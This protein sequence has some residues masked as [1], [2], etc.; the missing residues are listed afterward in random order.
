MSE[1]RGQFRLSEIQVHN[2]GTFDGLHRT[3][4]DRTGHLVTGPSGSG[5]STLI[6]AV[7]AVLISAP[8]F[9]AAAQATRSSGRNLISYARGAWRREHSAEFD[10]LTQSFLRTGA[11]W[12]GILLRYDNAAGDTVSAIRLMHLSRTAS[13]PADITNLFI[14]LPRSADLSEFE[15][16]AR[17]NLDLRRARKVF[18]D[19]LS[20]QRSHATFITVFRRELGIADP[21][22]LDLLY[23]TQSSKSLEDLNQLMREFMLPQPDTFRLADDA[24]EQFT[25]LNTAH[26]SVLTARDQIAALLPVRESHEGLNAAEAEQADNDEELD[27]LTTFEQTQA[28]Q[29]V[30]D[31]MDT[32]SKEVAAAETQVSEAEA[33]KNLLQERKEKLQQQLHGEQGVGLVSARADLAEQTHTLT[34]V[35]GDRDAYERQARILG[36]DTP[37]TPEQFETVTF[38]LQGYVTELE[39]QL[40]EKAG[41]RQQLY[42]ATSEASRRR[43]ALQKELQ[44][45]REFASAMDS[46][47]LE[48][49]EAISRLT[50]IPRA[51]L[52]FIADLLEMQTGEEGWQLAAERALG[53]F[54]RQLLVPDE[55]YEKVS[56]AVDAHNL[57]TRLR[58][59][60]VTPE[61]LRREPDRFVPGTL[62]TKIAVQPGRFHQWLQS[63]LSRRF[64]HRC[65]EELADFR[66]ENRAIT[67]RGQIKHDVHRHEKDD[68]PHID[69]PSRWVLTANLDLKIETLQAQL[70]DARA[71]EEKAAA[72]TRALESSIRALEEQRTAAD[73]LLETTEFRVIDTRSARRALESAQRRVDELADAQPQIKQ[74]QIELERA[75][76]QVD[77]QTDT[78]KHL[79]GVVATVKNDL[80]DS[81]RKAEH[82]T[83]ELAG[84]PELPAEVADRL[85]AHYTALSRSIRPDNLSVDTRT[86]RE[87]LSRRRAQLHRRILELDNTAKRAME[88]YLDRW[89]ERRGDLVAESPY[90]PDFIAHLARLEGDDLPRFEEKFREMLREQTQI[91]LSRLLREIS[92]AL[93]KIRDGIEQINISLLGAEFDTGVHLRIDV[94]PAQPAVAREFVDKLRQVTDGALAEETLAE[95]EERFLHIREVIEL[96][97]VSDENPDRLR[98][99]RLDTRLHVKFLGVEI[100][101]AGERGAVYDS[102]SGLSGGQAQKLGAFCLAAALRYQLIG[103]GLPTKRALNCVVEV[104]GTD[105]PKF[106]TVI[107]DEAF[108]RADVEFT[109]KALDAFTSFGFH[110]VLATPEKMIQTIGEYVRGTTYVTCP[111][112][113][114]SYQAT[115]MMEDANAP[116]D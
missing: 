86:I 58:F 82:L 38:Q 19:A 71:A 107:L 93:Q 98:R 4:V 25:E 68:R 102:S 6:D 1:Y 74:L 87:Q 45:V 16:T 99:Q 2:W 57:R 91:N 65:V 8:K 89:P 63:E 90:R 9:N 115:L 69:D 110:M 41:H 106:G 49:R 96:L 28:L 51:E 78:W 37:D 7:T 60:R 46:R 14:L 64:D 42:S 13:A 104:D 12:S 103:A 40:G 33:R 114:H 105:V 84:V 100:D 35:S 34:R 80:K 10:E 55:H 18:D 26:Q 50:D 79:I 62:G 52:P 95:E 85:R 36:V 29:H 59:I 43:D 24:T 47:L 54:A 56:A 73:R 30:T 112:R 53:G 83:R 21:A 61:L 23:Q 66:R 70:R 3:P 94:S 88:R 22:A 81:R 101:N 39:V 111:D 31:L 77:E 72:D 44:S 116:A 67:R 108:D 75:Q 97:T 76:V 27:H 113:K 92:T 17:D 5:K 32:L 109:R 15:V 48:A 20:I 11:M